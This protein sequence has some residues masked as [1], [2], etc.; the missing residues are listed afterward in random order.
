MTGSFLGLNRRDLLMVVACGLAFTAVVLSQGHVAPPPGPPSEDVI[1]HL[2]G[3]L[4]V[5]AAQLRRAIDIVP[6]PARG[7][8]WSPEQHDKARQEFATVLNLPAGRLDTVMRHRHPPPR[9]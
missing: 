1:Q 6:P 9:D 8:R 7:E 4:G 5:T 2:A 3:R